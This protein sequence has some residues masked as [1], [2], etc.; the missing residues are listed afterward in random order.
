MN[1]ARNIKEMFNLYCWTKHL[2]ALMKIKYGIFYMKLTRFEFRINKKE[3][4]DALTK[5]INE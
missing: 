5:R 2:C 1:D 4:R 3:T